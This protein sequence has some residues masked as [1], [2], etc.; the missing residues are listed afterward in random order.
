[1]PASDVSPTSRQ[2]S[3]TSRSSS[4]RALPVNDRA[5]ASPWAMTGTIVSRTTALNSASLMSK[6]RLRVPLVTPARRATSSS[7][8]AATPRSTN[9]SSAAATISPGRASLRRCQRGGRA[10]FDGVTALLTMIPPDLV[11]ERSVSKS[12]SPRSSRGPVRYRAVGTNLIQFNELAA[13]EENQPGGRRGE[14]QL[15]QQCHQLAAVIR[16][17][18]HDVAKHLAECVHILAAARGSDGHGLR[19]AGLVEPRQERQPLRFDGF[20][21]GA[22]RG[23]SREVF[24][25]GDRGIRPAEPAVEPQ[26]FRPDDVAH[27]AVQPA[28]TALQVANVRLG[29]HPLERREACAIGPGV[30]REQLPHPG[31]VHRPSG[32]TSRL[33]APRRRARSPSP[34]CPRSPD[35]RR[36]PNRAPCSAPRAHSSPGCC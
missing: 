28:M 23:Q 25:L 21:P 15:A 18:V 10:R 11:T 32:A 3:R 5:S 2:Y 19:Q 20:P 8:A 17:V 7:L 12:G 31:Q 4:S 33:P 27:R 30:V 16:G 6:Y 9:T 26:L 13:I 24:A 34:S 35:R 36:S 22:R 29:G 14:P 1:M